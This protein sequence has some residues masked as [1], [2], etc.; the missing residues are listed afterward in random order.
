MIQ[1]QQSAK[2]NI[3]DANLSCQKNFR[4]V[5]ILGTNMW[6]CWNFRWD[7]LGDSSPYRSN[8]FSFASAFFWQNV[9]Y[10]LIGQPPLNNVSKQHN[11][12]PRPPIY[13]RIVRACHPEHS[14]PML[15]SHFAIDE[16]GD[17]S[18]KRFV[19]AGCPVK[20]R[21]TRQNV[22]GKKEREKKT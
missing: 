2:V 18:G 11:F 3:N 9:P 8:V 19:L 4:R 10:R 16:H 1:L 21:C 12:A 14:I 20:Q 5:I 13:R 17:I 15:I 7:L 22:C 6:Q